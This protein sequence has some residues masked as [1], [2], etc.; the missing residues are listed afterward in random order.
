MNFNYFNN[1]FNYQNNK[2][3]SN[4]NTY[5]NVQQSTFNS[6]P[7]QLEDTF[8]NLIY[9]KISQSGLEVLRK[10]E[11]MDKYKIMIYGLDYLMFNNNFIIAIQNKW[12]NRKPTNNDIIQF[13]KVIQKISEIENK[14]CLGIY[15]SKLSITLS[16]RSAFEQENLSSLT[17][18]F[19]E[20][21]SESQQDVL[22]MLQ[23]TLY[24]YGV[25]FY[26]PDGSVI[27]LNM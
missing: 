21:N 18:R 23:D 9:A 5:F 11:I 10:N 4:N 1:N 13:V 22:K 25:H 8:E 2:M 16:A 17:N 14:C 3:I 20:I 24:D 26:E 6:N 7:L 19:V 15:L 27:M 12:N